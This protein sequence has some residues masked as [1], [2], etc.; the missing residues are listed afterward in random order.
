MSCFFV[1]FLFLITSW[2]PCDHSS[3]RTF[4]LCF[5][6]DSSNLKFQVLRCNRGQTDHQR[7]MVKY[8]IARQKAVD[9]WRDATTPK[10]AIDGEAPVAQIGRLREAA[11]ERL[12][13]KARRDW[14]GAADGLAAAVAA[15]AL[16]EATDAMRQAAIETVWRVNRR[17]NLSALMALVMADLSEAQREIFMNLIYQRNIALTDLTLHQLRDFL[18][19]LFHAPK[20]SL[21]NPSWAHKSGPRSFLPISYGELDQYEGHWVLDET[22]GDEGFLDE[23]EDLFWVY[24]E[25]QCFW[26]KYPCQGRSLRKGGK[27]KGGKGEAGQVQRRRFNDSPVLPAIPGGKGKKSGKG[28]SSSASKANIAEEEVEEEEIEDDALLADKQ[29]RKRRPQA[30]KKGKAQPAA[31][32]AHEADAAVDDDGLAYSAISFPYD[33]ISSN[34]EWCLKGAKGV[35]EEAEDGTSIGKMIFWDRQDFQFRF[36]IVHTLISGLILHCQF[37]VD[38]WKVANQ[39]QKKGGGLFA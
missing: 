34:K 22:T 15:V 16:P 35:Q 28:G 19:A 18:I 23:H 38:F 24:D 30:K 10:P 20:S 37:P 21:E 9:A 14:A 8:E 11:R 12:R 6:I 2:L 4:S 33:M 5:S 17:D 13:A 39:P 31:S 3:S 32:A 29:K 7:W 36:F 1:P 26:M 25:D 27:S